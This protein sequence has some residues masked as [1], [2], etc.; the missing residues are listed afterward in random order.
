MNL[1]QRYIDDTKNFHVIKDIE[2]DKMLSSQDKLEIESNLKKVL[3]AFD[4]KKKILIPKSLINITNNNNNLKNINLDKNDKKKSNVQIPY[5]NFELSEFKR[6]DSYIIYSSKEREKI[7]MKDYEAKSADYLFLEYNGDFMKIE[8][9][10]KIISALENSI[11]KGEKIPD[12]M[13][14]KIIEEKFSKYKS[15]SEIIIKYFNDRRNELKKSLLR[16]YWRLQKSTDKYFT[17]TFRRREREKMKIR[18]NNQKKEE[19]FDKIKKAGDLCETHILSIIKSMIKKEN[20]NKQL[21]YLENLDFL[22]KISIMRKN[23]IS[24]EYVNKNKEIISY[25]KN[26]GINLEENPQPKKEEK[27][28]EEGNEE[29]NPIKVKIPKKEGELE[30]YLSTTESKINLQDLIE[31]PLDYSSIK[32]N[33]K[34]DNNNKIKDKLRLRIRFNRNKAL[35][36]DRYIQNKNS[37]DP[38]DDSFNDNIFHYG[39]YSEN[40]NE[41]SINYN[42]FE[43]FLKEYYQQKYKYLEYIIDSDEDFDNFFKTKKINKRLLSKKRGYNK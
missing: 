23:E 36:V 16:K 27:K 20:L 38:F 21:I 15:K 9:L 37:M 24:E 34:E 12:E 11:G 31:P 2:S 13:A 32:N 7:Q 14:K 42:C 10:E 39:K 30:L 19:S 22:S 43:H 25:M 33:K 41:D 18:K 17:S 29:K 5:L 3:H 6:P 26:N 28:E 8:E 1:K 40:L 4:T 35:S